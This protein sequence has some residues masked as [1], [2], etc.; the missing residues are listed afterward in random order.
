MGETAKLNLCERHLSYLHAKESLCAKCEEERK[1]SAKTFG[2]QIAT[3][4]VLAFGIL[5]LGALLLT[6]FWM[7]EGVRASISKPYQL[8]WGV[9]LAGLVTFIFARLNNSYNLEAARVPEKI[10]I[11][12][13]LRSTIAQYTWLDTPRFVLLTKRDDIKAI[14]KYVPGKHCAGI[15]RWVS[16]FE[17]YSAAIDTREKSKK[18]D[19]PLYQ[20]TVKAYEQ[21]IRAM[22]LPFLNFIQKTIDSLEAPTPFVFLQ[23]N[24]HKEFK[25]EAEKMAS[26]PPL[27]EKEPPQKPETDLE[28][29]GRAILDLLDLAAAY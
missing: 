22:G 19:R 23:I 20:E 8:Y 1:E 17:A 13:R 26:P 6:I 28:E 2:T 7:I 5:I 3:L 14:G 12:A 10:D 16:L 24:P 11:A 18:E 15:L 4:L 29:S 9:V 21:E 25:I 27:P